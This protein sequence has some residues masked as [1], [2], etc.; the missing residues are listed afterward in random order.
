M[1]VDLGKLSDDICIVCGKAAR[2][3]N[4]YP[5][6]SEPDGSHVARMVSSELREAMAHLC[7]EQWSGWMRYLFS[8]GALNEDGTWTMPSWAVKRWQRQMIT[9]YSDL[10]EDE[11]DSDRKEADRFLALFAA[12]GGHE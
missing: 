7:H 5:M 10:S 9:P 12:N 11:Q 2:R 6:H 1:S 4:G 3:V 8:K